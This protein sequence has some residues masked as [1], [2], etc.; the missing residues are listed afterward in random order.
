MYFSTTLQAKYPDF[1][2]QTAFL[3]GY[4]RMLP[5]DQRAS[6]EAIE[7]AKAMG[8]DLGPNETYVRPFSK[9]VFVRNKPLQR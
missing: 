9:T 8:Y 7:L 1:D 4:I 5:A 3:N 2:A 6:Q